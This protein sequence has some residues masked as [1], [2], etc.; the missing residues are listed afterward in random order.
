MKKILISLIVISAVALSFVLTSP[1][2][3]ETVPGGG[4]SGG[5]VSARGDDQP[6]ELFGDMGIFKQITNIALFL[7][8]AISVI[9]IIFGGFRYIISGGD[10]ANVT[11]AKNTIMYAIVGI[12]VALLAY[13][14]VDFVIGVFSGG[15]GFSGGGSDATNF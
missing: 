12:I 2:G 8:G 10:S 4:V 14:A 13:A 6:T 1:V 3:A 5:A 9:M 11:A 7:I 15:S